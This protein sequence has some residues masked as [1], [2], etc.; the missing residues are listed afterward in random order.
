M[1]YD[2]QY[3]AKSD[4][5]SNTQADERGGMKPMIIDTHAHYDDEAF[6]DDRERVLE[7]LEPGGIYRVVNIGASL[8]S[9]QVSLALA[10]SHEYIYAAV[11]I[12]PEHAQEM[13]EAKLECLR[14]MSTEPEVVAWGE[15]GLDY[16][17][18]APSRNIQK[19]CFVRQLEA[20]RE[21]KLPIAVHSRDA[22]QDTLDI[23]TA[24][25]AGEIGGVVHCYSYGVELAKKYLDMGMYFGIGGVITFKNARKLAEVV[26]YLPMDAIVL[27]TDCPYMAPAPYRGKRNNST[28]LQ[29]VVQRIAQIKNI[30]QED[31]MRITG[32]NAYKL[33]PKLGEC[34]W[35]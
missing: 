11:G 18:E 9:S 24:N 2:I 10:K 33:Y 12:H 21:M 29:Y 15:I 16:H 7:S 22:A 13:A 26:E 3:G 31:V 25:R 14:R 1:K 6:D 8:E 20:A 19:D 28:L 32:I 34:P 4:M 5:Q 23:M 35:T 27:E 17:Y 30:P